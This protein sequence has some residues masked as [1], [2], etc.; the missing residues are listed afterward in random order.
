[1]QVE[2]QNMD[3]WWQLKETLQMDL[4]NLPE[5]PQENVPFI[6]IIAFNERI[7]PGTLSF[8]T[9]YG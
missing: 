1:M 8:L 5:P 4:K 3:K 2:H 7:A 9:S 6:T